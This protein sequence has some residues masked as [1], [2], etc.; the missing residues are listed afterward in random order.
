M[1]KWFEMIRKKSDK[2]E[3]LIRLNTFDNL[4]VIQ[5]KKQINVLQIKKSGN[6]VWVSFY[7]E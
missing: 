6:I 3:K 7:E 1:L 5:D 4:L 2:S